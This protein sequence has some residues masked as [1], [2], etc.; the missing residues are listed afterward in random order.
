MD[1]VALF[2]PVHGTDLYCL[3]QVETGGDLVNAYF[4]AGD[5]GNVLIDPLPLDDTAYEWI[6]RRG[7]VTQVVVLSGDRESQSH[8]IAARYG[9]RT[10]TRPAHRETLVRGV[11]AIALP[12]QRRANAF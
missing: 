4:L 5:S 12:D 8:A 1:G 7:G 9:A 3:T 2:A 10:V 11:F 6:E